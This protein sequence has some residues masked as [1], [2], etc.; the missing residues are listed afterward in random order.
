MYELLAAIIEQCM[1]MKHALLQSRNDD[2][3]KGTGHQCWAR[4]SQGQGLNM[5]GK[6]LM[7]IREQM[8]SYM[9]SELS[10]NYRAP[11]NDAKSPCYKC[12]EGNHSNS[13]CHHERSLKC[14]VCLYSGHKP[15]YCPDLR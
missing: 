9:E 10:I 1:E 8:S 4:G 11:K 6:L 7:Y 3:R 14:T 13:S 12:G 2:F 15:K 5:L